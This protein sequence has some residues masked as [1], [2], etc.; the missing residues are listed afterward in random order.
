MT[1]SA[2]RQFILD[3]L[4]FEQLIAAA[5]VLQCAREEELRATAA[6]PIPAPAPLDDS[7]ACQ[8]AANEAAV[9]ASPLGDDAADPSLSAPVSTGAVGPTAAFLR[10]SHELAGSLAKKIRSNVADTL[11]RVHLTALQS[12]ARE[13]LT[14]SLLH[15]RERAHATRKFRIVVRF[16]SDALNVL[17]TGRRVLPLTAP[18]FLLIA[19]AGLLVWQAVPR[20]TGVPQAETTPQITPAV[21]HFETNSAATVSLS[22][23]AALPAVSVVQASERVSSDTLAPPPVSTQVQTAVRTSPHAILRPGRHSESLPL[24]HARITDSASLARVRALS[25]F[26]IKSL[27]RSAQ[28]GD[29]ASAMVLAMAYETGHFIPQN[30]KKAAEWVSR[31]AAAGIPAAQYNLALRY[32]TGDG[33]QV[34]RRKA[35]Y[36]MRR[37]ARKRYPKAEIALAQV[38]GP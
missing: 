14:S 4:S 34:D 33:V 38:S 22:E 25:P 13:W 6:E 27:Q 20:K 35:Q 29:D 31:A 24:S 8:P 2:S 18:A 15:A 21:A 23:G 36:W 11:A 10:R 37:A 30:C 3:P 9:T 28:Y 19:T 7:V 32:N 26:E 17:N 1:Q 12:G 5:Y 16:T